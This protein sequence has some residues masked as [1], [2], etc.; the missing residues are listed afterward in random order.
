VRSPGHQEVSPKALESESV[1]ISFPVF[2]M[3]SFEQ[4]RQIDVFAEFFKKNPPVWTWDVC[5]KK[6][7]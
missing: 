4:D 5:E 7:F 1:P 3:Q 6:D 2:R